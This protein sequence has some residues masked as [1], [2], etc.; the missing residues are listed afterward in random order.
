MRLILDAGALI[1]IDRRDAQVRAFLEAAVRAELPVLASAAVVA[2][3][4]RG[5]ARQALLARVLRG[6]EVMA[7]TQTAAQQIGDLL[8]QCGT[9]DVVDA[10]VALLCR[11][12][13][14]LLTSDPGDL[15]RLLS[16]RAVTAAKVVAV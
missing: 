8:A 7:M 10:H 5:G 14:T 2:Q 6:I 4:W 9:R 3:V 16:A 13:D 12:G 11:A 1:G 15:G